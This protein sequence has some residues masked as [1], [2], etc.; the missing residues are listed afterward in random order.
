MR[1]TNCH[2]I[3][4]DHKNNTPNIAGRLVLDFDIKYQWVEH[5][6]CFICYNKSSKGMTDPWGY[7]YDFFAC[8]KCLS[9]INKQ[10]DVKNTVEPLIEKLRSDNN[11]S[12]IDLD[13]SI[14][15]PKSFKKQIE[16]IIIKTANK[17]YKNI[18]TDL[19]DFVWSTC[20]NNTKLSKHLT[21][22]NLC[23]EN[24]L[25]MCK[26]FYKF[27]SLEWN[28]KYDWIQSGKLIDFQILRKNTSLRM[29]G[30]KKINGN[31][32][33]MDNDKYTLADSLIR[34]YT[35]SDYSLEQII[36][37]NN[38]RPHMIPNDEKNVNI[39]A[40]QY[41]ESANIDKKLLQKEIVN[42][43]NDTDNK[44]A[45]DVYVNAFNIVNILCPGVFKMGKIS[46]DR[47]NLVR[48]K[49]YKCIM[50]DKIHDNENSY[51]FLNQSPDL[52]HVHFGCHRKCNEDYKTFNIGS[53]D[54]FDNSINY[55]NIFYMPSKFDNPKIFYI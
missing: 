14:F 31:I 52:I 28:K 22:K 15:I 49:K 43:N 41:L 39:P 51:V 23:F 24:W 35:E 16:E 26:Q 19:F 38:I 40:K 47:M 3:L 50:S 17:Y 20:A 4:I 21:V 29:V 34:I 30:S 12:I 1:Y 36:T 5:N 46:S 9:I 53:I 45:D 33:Y 18:N 55:V 25:S 44:F 42:T 54:A 2:E 7:G 32:L 11:I 48:L 10:V 13:Q 6:I 37:N 8:N 27:F